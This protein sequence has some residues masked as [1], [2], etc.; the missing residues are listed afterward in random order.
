MEQTERIIKT[1]T[2]FVKG[3]DTSD[4]DL[5]DS[6]L[7]KDF[8]VASSDF[9]GVPG[10]KLIDKEGYLSKIREGVFGGLPREMTIEEIDASGKIAMVK[11]RL[12]SAE[13]NF[14]SYNSLVLDEDG[15]WKIIHNLAVVAALD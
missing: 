13:N 8:R 14:V 4:T 1:V 12:T 10:V 15:H 3:G 7:H 6:V 11:L 5:L 9:M 2:H